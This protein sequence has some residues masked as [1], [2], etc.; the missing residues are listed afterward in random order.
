M[1]RITVSESKGAKTV[2][3]E[4]KIAGPWVEEFGRIW[5]ALATTPSAKEVCVDLRDVAFID[6]KGRELLREIYQ[7][8]EASFLTDSPLTRYFAEEAMR[9]SSNN[10]AKGV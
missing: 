1:L 2:K 10:G 7:E 5:Q 4:G 8:S 6:A 3:L 9:P